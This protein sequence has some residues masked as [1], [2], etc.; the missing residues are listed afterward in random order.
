VPY[1]VGMSA[2]EVIENAEGFQDRSVDKYN[3]TTGCMAW[4]MQRSV[5]SIVCEKGWGYTYL[6]VGV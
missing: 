1:Y 3:K 2:A 5:G 4:D 6:Q